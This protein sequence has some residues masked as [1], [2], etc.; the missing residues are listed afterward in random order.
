MMK[1]YIKVGVLLFIG[2]CT[3]RNQNCDLLQ[4]LFPEP[5]A[6]GWVVPIENIW[7]HSDSIQDLI[8]AGNSDW[9]YLKISQNYLHYELADLRNNC[10]NQP[11]FCYPLRRRD[12]FEV[13]VNS[14]NTILVEGEVATLT[15][16]DSLFQVVYLNPD[17]NKN[18]VTKP[19]SSAITLK[20]DVRASKD[21]VEL[22]IKELMIGYENSIASL[23]KTS[24]KQEACDSIISNFEKIKYDYPFNLQ[25]YCG[26]EFTLGGRVP[27]PP[28]PPPL[29]FI[30]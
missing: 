21:T 29:E 15:D 2:A 17:Q 19:K 3:T 11:P 23:Y 25:L 13:L 6:H 27:L 22:V 8:C 14:E 30:E 24:S 1:T 12:R 9:L 26:S 7:E 28:P 16:I 5:P 18:Y 10:P 4:V 20:W